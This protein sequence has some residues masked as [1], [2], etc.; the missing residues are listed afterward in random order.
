MKKRSRSLTLLLALVLTLALAAPAFA[1]EYTV[2][3]G[4]SLSKI[5]EKTLGD[6]SRWQEIYE[7]NKDTIKDPNKIYVGQKLIIPDGEEPAA[8][9]A[10][11]A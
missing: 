6:A 4:D 9:A 5:A 1:A 8:P 3:A 11:G 7:A 2:E 10:P